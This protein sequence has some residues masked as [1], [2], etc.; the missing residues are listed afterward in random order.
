MGK[1]I[2]FVFLG[3]ESRP[4]YLSGNII[5][6]LYL[7]KDEIKNIEECVKNT[8]IKKNNISKIEKYADICINHPPCAFFQTKPYIKWLY[9]GFPFSEKEINKIIKYKKKKPNRN[10]NILHAPSNPKTKGTKIISEII[11]KLKNEGKKIDYIE[12]IDLSNTEVLE[13]IGKCDFV[14]DELYSDIPIGRLGVETAFAGKTIVNA[15]Y[16]G[17][18]INKDYDKE[19]I[20]PTIYCEPSKIEN[21]IRLLISDYNLRSKSGKKNYEFVLNNWKAKDVANRYINII[22]NNIPK[23]WFGDPYD[24]HYIYGYG[25][26]KEQ[27]QKVIDAIIY[28]KGIDG[29]GISDK[30]YLIK[31]LIFKC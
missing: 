3:T 21:E 31:K 18:F 2:I 13:L 24:L 20:P 26:S 17:E 5:N 23:I 4:D 19:V 11:G 15:G 28:K 8:L 1:K 27:L 7:K 14:I 30:P 16:Y 10:V 25:Q 29:F 12:L 22:K 9:I 6:D